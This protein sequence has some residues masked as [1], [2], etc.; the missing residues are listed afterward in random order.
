METAFAVR[1]IEQVCHIEQY[2]QQVSKKE[3]RELSRDGAALEWITQHAA[4][5]P[6]LNTI[7]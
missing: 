1:M 5:F 6:E 2:R 3:G 4:L 7:S